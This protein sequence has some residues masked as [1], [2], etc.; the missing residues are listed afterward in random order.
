M[1]IEQ[2]HAQ[3]CTVDSRRFKGRSGKYSVISKNWAVAYM[4]VMLKSEGKWKSAI[5]LCSEL[6]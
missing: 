3:M 4:Y 1:G 2:G 6:C 5:I